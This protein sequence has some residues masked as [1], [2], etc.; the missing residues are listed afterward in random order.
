MCMWQSQAFGGALSL[1]GS[2]PDEN[3]TVSAWPVRT[4]SPEMAATAAAPAVPLRNSRRCMA[5]SHIG[6]DCRGG[7]RDYRLKP[8]RSKVRAT[9]LGLRNALRRRPSM[10]V[11]LLAAI[12]AVA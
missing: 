6:A 2:L 7:R 9:R 3:G 12:A 5:S 10:L 1:G 8:G 11:R 4:E